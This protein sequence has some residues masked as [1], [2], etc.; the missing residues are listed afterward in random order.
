MDAGGDEEVVAREAGHGEDVGYIVHHYVHSCELGPDLREDAD[1][2]PV[3]HVGLEELEEGGVGVAAFE[4]ANVFNVLEFLGDE[5]AVWVTFAVDEGEHGMAVFPAIFAREPARGF[6]EEA[7]ADEEKDGRDHLD[8]PRDAECGGA[9]DFRAAVGNVEH[10]H[11]APGD[12]PLLSP[13]QTASLAWWSQFRD[14]YRDL[15]RADADAETVYE[16]ADDQHS[17]VLGG[18]DDDGA[19]DPVD[20]LIQRTFL[21]ALSADASYQIHEPTMIAVFRPNMSERKPEKRAASHEP[22][23]IEAVIPPWTLDLGPVQ[24]AEV[25]GV[26][27]WLK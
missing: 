22:P 15:G 7:H 24:S 25:A 3:D 4:F 26:G 8:T 17:D 16:A 20:F 10:D 5:G 18:T 9:V 13:D 2:G 19:D 27:P 14:V 23:A 1:V 11:D 12:S 21:T 6:G